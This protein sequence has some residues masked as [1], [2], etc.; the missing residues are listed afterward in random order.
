MKEVCPRIED[1]ERHQFMYNVAVDHDPKNL[2]KFKGFLRDAIAM[3]R[4]GVADVF[5]VEDDLNTVT[6]EIALNIAQLEKVFILGQ[7][8]INVPNANTFHAFRHLSMERL[9]KW[10]LRSKRWREEWQS[11]SFWP[12][13]SLPRLSTQIPKHRFSVPW[14]HSILLCGNSVPPFITPKPT[15]T[16][17]LLN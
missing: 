16:I 1:K 4:E 17:L 11:R 12:R 5:G 6:D 14:R 3:N 9:H 8:N 15:R 13:S 10:T 7:V 2:E